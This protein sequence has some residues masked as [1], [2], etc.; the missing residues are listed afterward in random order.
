M[1]VARVVVGPS[2]IDQTL[3]G[4][5]TLLRTCVF[6]FIVMGPCG[7]TRGDVLCLDIVFKR[8]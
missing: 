2:C 4:C 7:G 3:V 6:L 1:C 5:L 8:A